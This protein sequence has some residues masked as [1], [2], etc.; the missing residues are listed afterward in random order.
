MTLGSVVISPGVPESDSVLMSLQDTARTPL[1]CE[2]PLW[3]LVLDGLAPW[4]L[5]ANRND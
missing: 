1:L 4:S 2:N 3:F 5:F